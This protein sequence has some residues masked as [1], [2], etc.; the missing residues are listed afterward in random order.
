MGRHGYRWH[1][2]TCLQLELILIS[3]TCGKNFDAYIDIM[4]Q[5]WHNICKYSLLQSHQPLN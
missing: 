3:K 1:I 4:Q 5:G 2:C